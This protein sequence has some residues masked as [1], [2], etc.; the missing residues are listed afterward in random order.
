M[1][2]SLLLNIIPLLHFPIPRKVEHGTIMMFKRL[3]MP[4]HK[5]IRIEDGNQFSYS[6]QNQM[7]HDDEK[8]ATARNLAQLCWWWFWFFSLHRAHL[9]SSIYSIRGGQ[10]S[11]IRVTS[12]ETLNSHIRVTPFQFVL[13][14]PTLLLAVIMEIE[15]HKLNGELGG[16]FVP[17]PASSCWDF[18][19]MQSLLLN[20]TSIFPLTEP[21]NVNSIKIFPFSA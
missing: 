2:D 17:L 15:T 10:K 16:E 20:L 13:I 4:P 19:R 14:T 9:S 18:D 12:N 7:D 11:S 6:S 8:A 1:S 21:R 3:S 5:K